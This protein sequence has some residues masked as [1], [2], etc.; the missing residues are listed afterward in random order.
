M[1][2][3]EP[4]GALVVEV[5]EGAFFE[6]LRAFFVFGD[7]PRVADGADIVVLSLRERIRLA[8]RDVYTGGIDVAFP[9]SV[10]GAGEFEDFGARP[11]GRIE[12][13]V[14]E[15]ASSSLAAAAWSPQVIL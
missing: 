7:D 3:V 2:Q 1:G 9:R 14:A 8:E 6:E 5:G 15:R 13:V 4:G 12:P 11:L 10:D